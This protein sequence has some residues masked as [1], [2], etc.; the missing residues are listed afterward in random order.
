VKS[1]LLKII[2]GNPNNLEEIRKQFMRW[3][4]ADGKVLEGL[5]RRR[6]AEVEVYCKLN[7]LSF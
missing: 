5:R 3:I 1:T 7:E 2:K 6:E 4:Y